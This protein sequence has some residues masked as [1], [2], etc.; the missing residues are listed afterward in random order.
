MSFHGTGDGRIFR[1]REL[2]LS[3]GNHDALARKTLGI[4]IA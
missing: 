2:G 4:T 3:K 1:F